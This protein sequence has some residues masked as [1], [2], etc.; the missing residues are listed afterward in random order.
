M[1]GE[2]NKEEERRPEIPFGSPLYELDPK[3]DL[4]L[5]LTA[6]RSCTI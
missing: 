5:S 2:L 3:T 4:M 6:S 1:T